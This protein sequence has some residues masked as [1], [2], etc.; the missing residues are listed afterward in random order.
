MAGPLHTNA[1]AGETSPYLLQ[2]AHNPVNWVPWGKDALNKARSESKLIIVSIG[3][4][5]CHWCHVME[6]ESFEDTA[7]AR[8]MN[9]H[10]VCIKVDREERPDI[11]HIFMTAVQLISQQGGWPLNCI[12]LPDGRPIWGGTY[13][14]KEQ[15]MEVLNQVQAYYRENPAKT[16]Q[17]AADLAEG[18]ARNSLFQDF[19][20][21]GPAVELDLQ[22]IVKNWSLQF[23]LEQGG[24]Q[25]A[26]KFPMPVNLEF[27]LQYGTQNKD[28]DVLQYVDLTL[29]KMA[30]GGIYDQVGGGFARYSVDQIWKVPHFEKML[31]DNAQLVGLYAQ[32]YQVFGREAYREVVVRSIEFLERELVSQEGAFYSALDADSEGEEGKFYVWSREELEGLLQG[33]F[34]LF[35]VYYNIN[36]GEKWENNSYILYRTAEPDVFAA[37]HGLDPGIFLQTVAHWNAILLEARNGRIRPGLDDKSLTSWNALMIS[38]LVKAYRAVGDPSFIEMALKC[39]K[40]VSE[41]MCSRDKVL[42]RSYKKGRHSIP[43]FLPD[44]AMTIEAF[45]DLYG[46]SMDEV[47][48]ELATELTQVTMDRFFDKGLGMFLYNAADTEVLITHH[49]E[50]RDNVIPSSNS[51][52][53]RNLFTVGHLLSK[54]D[55]IDLASSM[56]EQISARIEQY[57]NG[58]A[59]WGSLLLKY[60][61][62]FYE[63][64]VVGPDAP[65]ILKQLSEEYLP[66]AVIAASIS[67]NDLPLFKGRY[68]KDRTLIFVCRDN[69][70][71]LPLEDPEDAKAI[72]HQ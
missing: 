11:D 71:Q 61:H 12:A 67:E 1:L 7:V 72:Y 52:M 6:Q 55:Y 45:L 27:L 58:Y 20:S 41:E 28:Q 4:S 26:P 39:A 35:A 24:S 57:P 43:G 44:Y 5:S 15:W 68:R 34:D 25:G 50:I 53:A 9:E 66:Q 32:A 64:A 47:W 56:L 21:T 62:P 63:I 2:H 69:V 22:S 33:D 70:C 36:P 18:I 3:Y 10:F 29:T 17:Y 42:Y 13:L 19:S 23:D 54:K 14:T 60:Q 46:S 37:D 40:W 16:E 31:Y 30:R 49:T 48:L 65:R 38:G 51:V 59:G 8:L